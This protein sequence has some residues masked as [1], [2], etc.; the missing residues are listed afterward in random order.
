MKKPSKEPNYWSSAANHYGNW[1][2]PLSPVQEDMDVLQREMLDVASANQSARLK[3]LQL[4]VTPGISR[5]DWPADTDLVSVDRCKA[6]IDTLWSGSWPKDKSRVT[7]RVMHRDWLDLNGSDGR[8]HLVVSDGP[9]HNMPDI[10]SYGR[11][12]D[13]L[14]AQISGKKA[15]F[16]PLAWLRNNWGITILEKQRYTGH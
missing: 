12:S 6:M 5:L 11:L 10:E 2:S 15:G 13:V 3:V 7:R 9:F 16:I 4:G 14:Y 1:G 8:F